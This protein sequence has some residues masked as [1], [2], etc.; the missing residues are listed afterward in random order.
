MNKEKR[1]LEVMRML[2]E[3]SRKFKHKQDKI[4]GR[5]KNAKN[6]RKILINDWIKR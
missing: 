6:Y 1:S 5:I 4:N 3:S 2:L